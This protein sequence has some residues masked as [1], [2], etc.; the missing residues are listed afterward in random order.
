MFQQDDAAG[1]RRMM[2]GIVRKYGNY[3]EAQAALAAVEWSQASSGWASGGA[4]K[5]ESG[6]NPSRCPARALL[7]CRSTTAHPSS[8]F[9]LQC[10]AG[11]RRAGGGA[12]C[13]GTA[14]G[15]AVAGPGVGGAEHALAAGAGSSVHALPGHPGGRGAIEHFCGAGRHIGDYCREASSQRALLLVHQY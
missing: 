8:H 3:A 14:A 13:A 12:V 15:P 9:T 4:L 2:Q 1:A 11:R 7:L 10:H 5:I 6:A